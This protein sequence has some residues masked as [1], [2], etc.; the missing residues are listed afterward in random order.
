M[1][2]LERQIGQSALSPEEPVDLS[3]EKG[4]RNFFTEDEFKRGR[5]KSNISENSFQT[6]CRFMYSKLT[7][8]FMLGLP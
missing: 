6:S 3:L 7:A 8:L 1:L 2:G 4:R 5:S